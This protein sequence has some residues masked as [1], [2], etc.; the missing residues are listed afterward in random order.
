MCC[1]SPSPLRTLDMTFRLLAAGPQPLP[2]MVGLLAYGLSLS[3]S[4][5]CRPG[6]SIQRRAWACSVLCSWSLSD[7]PGG[8]A[9]PGPLDSPVSSYQA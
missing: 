8:T 2:W 9:A 5:T 3:G 7:G 1:S 4:W 6:C